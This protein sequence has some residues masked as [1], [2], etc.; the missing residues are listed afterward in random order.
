MAATQTQGLCEDRGS[1]WRSGRNRLV[2]DTPSKTSPLLL[3]KGRAVGGGLSN[4]RRVETRSEHC[5]CGCNADAGAMRRPRIGVA[6]GAK[7]LGGR[8]TLK[9]IPSLAIQRAGGRGSN[10]TIE[11]YLGRVNPN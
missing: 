4:D 10:R 9:D 2:G 1:E 5:S 3:L 7:P 6:V 8:Y 11:H